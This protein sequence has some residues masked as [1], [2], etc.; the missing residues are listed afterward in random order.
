MQ[1]CFYLSYLETF[2]FKD[3]QKN[4]A[5]NNKLSIFPCDANR[6]MKT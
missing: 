3:N 1:H 2:S 4:F 5:D 6:L